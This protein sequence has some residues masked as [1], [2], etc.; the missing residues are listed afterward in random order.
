[1]SRLGFIF[2]EIMKHIKSLHFDDMHWLKL[3]PL[4][5]GISF[6]SDLKTK[7]LEFILEVGIRVEIEVHPSGKK[8]VHLDCLVQ[9]A[10]FKIWYPNAR[11]PIVYKWE[12]EKPSKL[13]KEDSEWMSNIELLKA[14]ELVLEDA[15]RSL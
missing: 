6:R 13:K 1:M 3:K 5:S 10:L 4:L 12:F 11:E 15:I 8:C 7:S 14:L 9:V 2:E